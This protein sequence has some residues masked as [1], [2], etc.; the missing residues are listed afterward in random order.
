MKKI[1]LVILMT[2]FSVLRAQII[3][4]PDP[5]FKALLLSADVT[6]NNHIA[7]N[8]SWQYIK[9]DTN[10]NGEIEVSE[11]QNVWALDISAYNITDLTGIQSFSNLNSLKVFGTK[12]QTLNVSG[13][14]NLNF[15]SIQGASQINAL[16]IANCTNLQTL[17]LLSNDSLTSLSLASSSLKAIT[18]FSG[19]LNQFD[20]SNCT[21][22]QS[23]SAT[24]TKITNLNLSNLPLLKTVDLVGAG[25][26]QNI[27]FQNSNKIYSIS[28]TGSKLTT[29]NVANL[30]ELWKLTCNNNYYLNTVNVSNCISMERLELNFNEIL[31][32]LNAS[33]LPSLQIL[34]IFWNNFSTVDTSA[35]TAL[36]LL[37]CSKNKL[38]TI[39]VSQNTKLT[40]LKCDENLFETLDLS[41]NSLLYTLECGKNNN[42][43]I[44]NLKNG[45]Q[46]FPTVS[47]NEIPQLQFLCCDNDKVGFFNNVLNNYGYTNVVTNTYCSF[48]PGGTFYV[49]KGNTK[50]DSNSNGC[51]FNDPAKAFQ[52]FNITSGVTSGSFIGNGSG[53][54]SVPLQAGSHI[55]TPVLESPSYFTITPPSAN[56]IFPNQS[57]PVTQNFCLT[58]NGNHNDLETVII[59]VTAASPGF[60]AQYKIIYKNKGTASQSGNIAFNFSNSL[61]TFQTST[62]NPN[63]QSA[64]VLNW[65]FT[66]L[67]PFETREIT[68]VLKLNTPTQIPSV[69]GGDILHFT[70]QV[71]GATDETPSDNNF[72]LNQMVVNSFDPNDKTCLEGTS[73]TQT[74]VG[75]YVHYLIR[76]ENTGT[77]NAKN[78]VVKDEIDTTK[79]DISS[80]VA[81]NG[82]H[83]FITR[84][85]SPNVVEF[86]FENIQLPFDDAHNDGYISFKIK[87][88]SILNLGDSFSNTAKIYFDYNHPIITNTFTTNVQNTVLKTSEINKNKN[89]FTIF[90]NPVKDVL[91][92]KSKQEIIKAEIY[93]MAGRIVT[94]MGI[95]GNSVNVSEL[96][97]GNYMLKVFTKDHTF[98]QKFIKE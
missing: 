71:N 91:I 12:I 51:D 64:N 89:S 76:F 14:Q 95:K 66:N 68:I 2:L 24:S 3:N 21:A 36:K 80:L 32:N 77:A 9:I 46:Y 22:L 39:D 20:I 17:Q 61:M 40:E 16:N 49:V 94:S 13:M 10:G 41:H 29:L 44:I 82:S 35:L 8:S 50:Y 96:S 84:I 56:V 88:K 58:A 7:S 60:N 25:Q 4:I 1:Y 83:N 86:I 31:S 59:P 57:S 93:D 75:D 45:F 5:A 34:D 62:I 37:K 27:D 74:Q 43:K 72:T 69:N 98:I 79:F 67:Q 42:L 26:L 33:G 87:T 19:K 54:Y 65:N 47:I 6:T 90:P 30:P 18:L 70:A 81:L 15:L 11:A 38:I 53:N 52:Q 97:K 23:F 55:I 28:I 63:S 85:T 73:I 92:I 78:I 48:T